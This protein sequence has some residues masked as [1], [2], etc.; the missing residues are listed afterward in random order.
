MA[1]N[2]HPHI[3]FGRVTIGH[4]LKTDAPKLED[5]TKNNEL[6]SKY[7][8][9]IVEKCIEKGWDAEVRRYPDN[10]YCSELD[11][12]WAYPITINSGG[13][14]YTYLIFSVKDYKYNYG[15][16]F[17]NKDY[18]CLNPFSPYYNQLNH[19]PMSMWSKYDEFTEIVKDVLGDCTEINGF[20]VDKSE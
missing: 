1:T 19:R 6:K 3:Y 5:N 4:H 18:Y 9:H 8:D 15:S 11:G 7:A 13:I 17:Y 12:T 16:P 2:S 20:G 14:L 10:G